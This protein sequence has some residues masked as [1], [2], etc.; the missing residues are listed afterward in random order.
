MFYCVCKT[1]FITYTGKEITTEL[2]ETSPPT[3]PPPTP[4]TS[5]PLT[6]TELHSKVVTTATD[7]IQI[8]TTDDED[9]TTGHD[10]S[11]TTS[12]QGGRKIFSSTTDSIDKSYSS[13]MTSTESG[14]TLYLEISGSGSGSG[15]GTES[16]SGSGNGNET[17]NDNDVKGLEGLAD[18][19]DYGLD[20][21]RQ[22]RREKRSLARLKHKLRIPSQ[23]QVV[24]ESPPDQA[25]IQRMKDVELQQKV[26]E[27]YSKEEDFEAKLKEVRELAAA[28]KRLKGKVIAPKSTTAS[29]AATLD[30]VLSSHLPE[31][32]PLVISEALIRPARDANMNF[33]NQRRDGVDAPEAMDWEHME[34]P[35]PEV[36]VASWRE[37]K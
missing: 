32:E 18:D 5:L 22:L 29:P 14:S 1:L 9:T 12:P 28:K 20:Y 24:V 25:D 33:Y 37:K 16:G 36:P 13:T 17:V 34:H 7:D 26:R 4:T 6:T 19:E 3:L 8:T 30:P 23:N 21:K 31:S 15:S 11:P 27:M 35:L 2:P 10:M